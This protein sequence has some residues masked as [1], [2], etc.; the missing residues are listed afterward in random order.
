MGNSGSGCGR[1]A[2][3]CAK[4]ARNVTKKKIV[5]RD[6]HETTVFGVPLLAAKGYQTVG[7]RP[8]KMGK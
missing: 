5:R 4:P 3:R 8:L 7:G 2:L 1:K 6:L